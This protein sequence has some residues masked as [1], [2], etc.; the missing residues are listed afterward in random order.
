[1]IT[2]FIDNLVLKIVE[3]IISR[4]I[5]VISQER[6]IYFCCVSTEPVEQKRIWELAA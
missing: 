5:A 1:M 2:F 3:I 6:S 4:A